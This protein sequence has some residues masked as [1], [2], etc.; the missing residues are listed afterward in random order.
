[1]RREQ[2]ESMPIVAHSSDRQKSERRQLILKFGPG[3]P[4]AHPGKHKQGEI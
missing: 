2:L 1:M 3:W 4:D